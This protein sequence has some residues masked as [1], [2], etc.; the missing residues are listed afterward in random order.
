MIL[1][2]NYKDGYLRSR[3]STIAGLALF[4]A[5]L[6]PSQIFAQISTASC[7]SVSD[8]DFEGSGGDPDNLFSYNVPDIAGTGLD[9]GVT[10]TDE[11]E[12]I[13]YV[14]HRDKL[15]FG[16]G[17]EIWVSE[18]PNYATLTSCGVIA[19]VTDI[20]GMAYDANLDVFYISDRNGTAAPGGGGAGGAGAP[21]DELRVVRIDDATCTVSAVAGPFNIPTTA[22]TPAP[23]L[24]D[25]DDLAVDPIS[26]TLYGIANNSNESDSFLITID[27]ADGSVLTTVAMDLGF[28]GGGNVDEDAEG[29]TFTPSGDLLVSLGESA[30]QT[31]NTEGPNSNEVFVLNTVTGVGTRIADI[32]A[33]IASTRSDME[34]ITCGQPEL[35]LGDTVWYDFD[36]SGT[37]NGAEVGLDGVDLLLIKDTTGDGTPDTQVD[38]QTTTTVSG[39][40]GMYMFGNLMPGTYLICV[41]AA[42]FGNGGTLENF[43]SSDGNG[44]DAPDPDDDVDSDD[45]GAPDGTGQICT[46]PISLQIGSEPLDNPDAVGPSSYNPTLDLGL[47]LDPL[48]PVEM[49][50]FEVEIVEM[51]A[52]LAWT[53]ASEK[54]NVGFTVE[55]SFNGEEYSEKGFVTGNGTVDT[56]SAY[57]FTAENLSPGSY[58]FRLKQV[59]Y[60]GTTSYSQ[61]LSA[62]VDLPGDYL[63]ES[64]YPNPFNPSTKI[65]F[66]VRER[67][68]VRMALYDAS[69]REIKTLFEGSPEA[70]T[71]QEVTI[72]ASSLPSGTYLVRLAGT[73][74]STTQTITLIK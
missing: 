32:S 69:G 7:F 38:S 18:G 11:V 24:A 51:N 64:A 36:N 29:L 47:I 35:K 67:Q 63:L 49:T 20:D 3:L 25:V 6:A 23:G 41:P 48:L 59:D 12:A 60:D 68:E 42:E 2:N 37:L 72:E 13:E 50:S 74:F 15:Y 55:M 17:T 65:S 70:G 62:I 45:N 39:T 22:A 19:G 14:T 34:S 46:D 66:T 28:D 33:D 61:V 10:G 30:G 56:E 21:D 54:S 43:V 57:S 58:N 31:A 26:G 44:A 8:H 73:E 52:E 40:A 71:A 53:T 5:L 4:V 1:A 16:D 9:L 27:P